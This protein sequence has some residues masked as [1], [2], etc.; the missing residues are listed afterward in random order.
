MPLI[1][2][3]KLPLAPLSKKAAAA[4]RGEDHALEETQ[5][6]LQGD[7]F[8]R[9]RHPYETIKLVTP[10]FSEELIRRIESEIWRYEGR[11]KTGNGQRIP[12]AYRFPKI[13][14]PESWGT[15][16]AARLEV[17]LAI[18]ERLPA[19]PEQSQTINQLACVIQHVETIAQRRFQEVS[20]LYL[21]DPLPIRLPEPLPETVKLGAVKQRILVSYATRHVTLFREDGAVQ[22]QLTPER[23]EKLAYV[24]RA[25]IPGLVILTKPG[26]SG[27]DFWKP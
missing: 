6:A 19:L 23:P 16:K 26:T 2:S 24:E 11:Y 22:V 14:N 9:T 15:N 13:D 17:I 21:P 25:K 1:S 3:L 18:F 27:W 10:V 7:E 20:H 8:R 5:D 4:L 12:P